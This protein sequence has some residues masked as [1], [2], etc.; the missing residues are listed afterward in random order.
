VSSKNA[1]STSTSIDIGTVEDGRQSPVDKPTLRRTF[2]RMVTMKEKD[3]P[4]VP[5]Q[6]FS[7]LNILSVVSFVTTIGL[8]IWVCLD[9][10]LFLLHFMS[11]NAWLGS[12]VP[13]NN[14]FQLILC[15]QL[16]KSL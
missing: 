15:S 4:R 1:F 16:T 14:D 5:P 13:N 2:T 8:I 6:L 3:R 11:R 9:F 12:N 7:P 10:Q